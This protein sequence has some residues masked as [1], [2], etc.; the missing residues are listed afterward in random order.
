MYLPDQFEMS[1]EAT[2]KLL[3][4][5]GFGHLITPNDTGLEVTS[6]PWLY[7]AER[8]SLVSHVSRPNPH[9]QLTEDAESVAIIPNVDAYV[10]P[11]YYPSKYETHKV[12]PTWNYEILHIFGRLEA[13]DDRG[14]LL[15][16]VT[17]LTNHHEAGREKEWNVDEAP[18][19]FIDMQLRGI[20][21]IELHI[22]R[23]VAKAK[24]NQNRT[25]EDRSGVIRGLEKGTLTERATAAH[26]VE[27]GLDNAP[28]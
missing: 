3:R 1:D 27:Q 25:P 8:H 5:G 26:M 28:R 19:R 23:V 12:V 11:E 2:E 15:D 22:T 24:L 20:V 4:K 21:G 17:K 9:W 7:D 18:A 13:H 14:W 10:T 16:Q 6:V